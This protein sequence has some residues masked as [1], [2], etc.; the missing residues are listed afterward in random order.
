M[1]AAKAR[2]IVEIAVKNGANQVEDVEW[3]A[4]DPC[5]SYR[6]KRAALH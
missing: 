4:L 5:G 3:N 2:D 6:R 1:A